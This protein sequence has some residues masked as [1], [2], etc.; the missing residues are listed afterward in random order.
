M[1]LFYYPYEQNSLCD[2]RGW[3]ASGAEM[4]PQPDLCALR[5]SV[6]E[7]EVPEGLPGHV[8][9]MPPGEKRLECGIQPP[10]LAT[11]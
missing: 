1:T 4:Q 8:E 6:C 11:N 10:T 3:A 2:L 7:Q 9:T 5:H